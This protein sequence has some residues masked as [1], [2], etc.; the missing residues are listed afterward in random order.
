MVQSLAKDDFD[1]EEGSLFRRGMGGSLSEIA[2]VIEIGHD[3]M[4]IPHVRF[5]AHLM[6]GN[7][8]A[9]DSEQ[10]T[11]SLDSF[12]ARYKERVRFNEK[13]NRLESVL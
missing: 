2:E 13:L 6:R 9:T 5:N 10:R 8:S 7:G 3:K 4:G 1:I 11:L 12:C